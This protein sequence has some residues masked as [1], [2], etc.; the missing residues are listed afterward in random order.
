MAQNNFSLSAEQQRIICLYIQQYNQTND[1]IDQLLDSLDEIRGNIYDLIYNN[2]NRPRNFRNANSLINNF[3]NNHFESNIRINR[4][5][6]RSMRRN[7]NISYD[8]NR[9]I[10]PLLYTNQFMNNNTNLDTFLNTFLNS[11][12]TVRPSQDQI[13]QASR[14]VRYDNIVNPLSE[15]CPISLEPF[16]P[17]DMVR[18]INHCGHIFNDSPFQQW[19]QRNVRCPVCRYDIRTYR[20]RRT[21]FSTTE[22]QDRPAE[23]ENNE[24]SSIETENTENIPNPNPRNNASRNTKKI[25]L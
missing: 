8:F 21:T 12:V 5:N 11:T 16:R 22:N 10:N 23:S 1:H 24:S 2:N 13:N 18:Q 25:Q 3:V 17:T 15:S 19:F 14:L 7:N 4:N 20:N 6:Y 9:P